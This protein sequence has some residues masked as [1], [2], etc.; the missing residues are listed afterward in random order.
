MATTVPE[1]AQ[2][3]HPNERGIFPLAGKPYVWVRVNGVL[4]AKSAVKADGSPTPEAL[5]RLADAVRGR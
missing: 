3:L 2:G 4:C 5:D 1:W